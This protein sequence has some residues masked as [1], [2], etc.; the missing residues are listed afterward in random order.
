MASEVRIEG[1]SEFAAALRE[2]PKNISRKYLRATVSAAGKVIRDEARVNVSKDNPHVR[3]GTLRRAIALGRSNKRSKY[4]VEVFHVFVRQAMNKNGRGTKTVKAYGKFDAYYWYFL[5]F[6][7]SK[8]DKRPFMRPAFD[9]RK[10]DA[11]K[12]MQDVLA[13]KMPEIAKAA[14]LAWRKA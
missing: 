13:E 4:G 8:M 1:L 10:D 9:T 5:E 3:T 11:I 7:T 14:G 12:A 2:M 6:G